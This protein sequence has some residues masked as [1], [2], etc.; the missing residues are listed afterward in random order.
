MNGPDPWPLN[1]EVDIM[2]SVNGNT[3]N[4]MTLHTGEGGCVKVRRRSTGI[5]VGKGGN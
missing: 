1:G 2:E 5:R 4:Q 3:K